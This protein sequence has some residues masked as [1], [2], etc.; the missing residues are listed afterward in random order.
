MS[1][2]ETARRRRKA[3]TEVAPTVR[4]W[5]EQVFAAYLPDG[6][7]GEF[8]G[9]ADSR[10]DA[11]ILVREAMQGQDEASNRR[12]ILGAPGGSAQ[13]LRPPDDLNPD[14]VSA[15]SEAPS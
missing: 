4:Q 13:T 7:F 14:P 10:E 5:S 9:T 3:A 8:V 2:A 1:P 11:E 12:R 15:G 6:I